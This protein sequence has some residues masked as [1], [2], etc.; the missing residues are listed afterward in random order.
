VKQQ[1]LRRNDCQEGKRTLSG[2]NYKMEDFEGVV[3]FDNRRVSLRK[4]FVQW[5]FLF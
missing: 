1:Q 5:R 2:C 4:R 3:N